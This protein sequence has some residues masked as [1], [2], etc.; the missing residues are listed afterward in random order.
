MLLTAPSEDFKP[1]ITFSVP[2]CLLFLFLF[3]LS[4]AAFSSY[5]VHFFKVHSTVFHLSNSFPNDFLLQLHG[6]LILINLNVV[7]VLLTFIIAHVFISVR[8]LFLPLVVSYCCCPFISPSRTPFTISG[9][10]N[11]MAMDSLNF[12][13]SEYLNLSHIL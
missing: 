5:F 11:I 8:S 6:C 4:F 3:N 1:I 9:R 13:L 10:I 12:C 2:F 7:I